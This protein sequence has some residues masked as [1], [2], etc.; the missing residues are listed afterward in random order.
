MPNGD[1]NTYRISVEP[2]HSGKCEARLE[3]RFAESNW[4]LRVY[5]LTSRAGRVWP[6]L[7]EVLRTLQRQEEQLWIWGAERNARGPLF[8]ELLRD[9]GLELDRRREFPRG[10]RVLSVRSGE[11]P[12]TLQLAELKRKLSGRLAPS[13]RVTSRPL[14]T[15]RPSA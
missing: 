7:E 1:R 5:F 9:A 4:V 13:P 15:L 2:N 3:A 12:R 14:E 6:R 10:A 11:P 8:D